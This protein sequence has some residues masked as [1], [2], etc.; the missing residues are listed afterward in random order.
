[1]HGSHILL[2]GEMGNDA[3]RSGGTVGES[4]GT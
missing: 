4:K 2:V 1:M 3:H